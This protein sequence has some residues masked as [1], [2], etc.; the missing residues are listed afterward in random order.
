M[1]L[2]PTILLLLAA[3]DLVSAGFNLNSKSN[4][5]IYWGQNSAGQQSTQS[6]LSNYCSDAN[7]NIIILS[8]LLR[9]N[10]AGGQPVMNFAN[11]GDKCSLFPG[12]ETFNCP[13]IASDIPACQSQGKTILLSIGGDSYN[14]GGFSTS[15]AATD[16]ADKIWAM[17]G[18]VQSGSNALRPFSSA[19]VDGFDFDFEANVSNMATF[20]NQLRSHMNSATNKKYYLSA[21]PQCPFPD[22]YNKDIIDN[23]SLDFL[24]VQ[25]YNNG[26]G[27]SS[28]VPGASD[29]W[30]FNF[31]QWDDWAQ[32][33]SKN[34]AVKVLL[35]VPA[36]TGAGRGYL[37]PSQLQPVIQYSAK[38]SSFGGVMMW[39]A[40]QAWTNGNFVADV[41][42]SLISLSKK[43]TRSMRWGLRLYEDN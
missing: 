11:Q 13:E 9:F 17:F 25:F 43:A 19:I 10:G 27:A 36:N 22:W 29:Q 34:P 5:A 39:D 41:K 4:V 33:A 32:S 26:C 35:G 18:P 23:V 37:T 15:Q 31:N 6:R 24:N 38:Y 7:I 30:N 12:T 21:A 3:A 14:E 42:N 28:Y 8:F 40:S 2:L 20:A 16:S 1:C